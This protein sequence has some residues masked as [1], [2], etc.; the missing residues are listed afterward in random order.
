VLIVA[1]VATGV[2]SGI[3][4]MLVAM[5]LHFVEHL[6]FDYN[7]ASTIAQMT[8]FEGVSATSA[9]RR[10]WALCACGS[11]AGIG[12]WAVYRF[13]R[14]LISIAKAMSSEVR[15]PA[16]ATTAHVLLQTVTVGMGSPLGREAAP[17]EIGALLA[18]RLCDWM[19]LGEEERRVL[20]ACGA[21]GGLAAVYNVP[22]G[23]GLFA[24]E[25]LLGTFQWTAAIPVIASTAIAA[26]VARWGLGNEAQYALPGLV[27]KPALIVW[28]VPA[29]PVF[30]AVGYW[31][32]RSAAAARAQA[33]RDWRLP[34]SCIA[35]FPVIGALAIP[36]PEILGNGKTITQMGFDGG[37]TIQLAAVLLVIRASIPIASLRAGAEGGLL[38]PSLAAGALLGIV[39]GGLWSQV[40]PGVSPGAFAVVGAA[41]FLAA[42]QR[43]PVVA[44]A[45]VLELTG[46]GRDFVV[47]VIFAVAGSAAAAEWLRREPERVAG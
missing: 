18:G 19:R 26:F 4:G 9:A 28:S 11:I 29:G 47:P 23:A 45:L 44:V 27:M 35:V 41:A 16:F 36:F 21:G 33:P 42:S 17:R 30:G 2:I 31:F 5:L 32:S 38:T 13:G 43:M 34:I 37:V 46:A 15:M 10:F 6:T 3:A 20:I 25:T 39:L 40:W 14:P 24:L 8:F 7:R 1:T 22:F 12:W